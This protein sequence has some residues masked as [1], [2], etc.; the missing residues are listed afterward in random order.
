MTAFHNFPTP[1]AAA[2]ALAD[3]VARDLRTVL[4]QKGDAVL[5][6]SGGRSPVLFFQAL[7]QEDLDW[8]QVSVTLA[9]E[10]I[11][12]TNHPDSNTR[13]VRGHLLQHRAAAAQWLPLVEDGG[14]VPPPEEAVRI[15]LARYRPADVLVLGMGNDGHT[16]SLFP[17]APQLSD[18]LSP[19]YPQPLLHVSPPAAPHERIS[20]TLAAA[21]RVPHVYLAVGGEEKRRILEQALA[22]PAQY[23]VGRMIAAAQRAAV[24]CSRTA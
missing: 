8:A 23:P 24:Y 15:A 16:A 6:V 13:L 20:L 11:V 9:D 4:A 12:P 10:R 17:D 7:S 1:E 22:A 3:T 21:A 2:R 18:G 5:A 19:D 14:S